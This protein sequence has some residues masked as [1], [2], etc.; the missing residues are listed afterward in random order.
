MGEGFEDDQSVM[1]QTAHSNQ[2]GKKLQVACKQYLEGGPADEEEL[3][4]VVM[5][6]E[7]TDDP[8]ASSKAFKDL[9]CKT[10]CAPQ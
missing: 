2:W 4:A 3:A 7:K 1:L 10:A 9:L 6:A 8:E 5:E